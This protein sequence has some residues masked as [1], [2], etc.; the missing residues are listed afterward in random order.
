MA[1]Y[2]KLGRFVAGVVAVALL[3]AAQPPGSTPSPAPPTPPSS[4]G[5]PLPPSVGPGPA[6]PVPFVPP[7]ASGPLP[8]V[9]GTMPAPARRFDFK[10]DPKATAKDLL[11]LAPKVSPIR[12]PVT[13]DDL[14]AIPEIDFSALPEKGTP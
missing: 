8:P 3:G 14:K 4:P 1:D 9:I 7:D 2:R 5:T 11:P 6:T 10:I 13:A 12:G